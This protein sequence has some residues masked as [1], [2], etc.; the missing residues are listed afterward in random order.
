[1]MDL[2]LF[3]QKIAIAPDGETLQVEK[4]FT[5][6][7]KVFCHLQNQGFKKRAKKRKKT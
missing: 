3:S 7:K 1:M 6:W 5:R 2:G 4:D